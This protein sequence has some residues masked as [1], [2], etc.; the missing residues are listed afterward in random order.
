MIDI[1]ALIPVHNRRDT[2]VRM[3]TSLKSAAVPGDVRLTICV[4]DDG[5][6]DGTAEAI[7][8][9]FPDVR[10]EPADGGLF[11]SGSVRHGIDL[12]LDSQ[13]S[14]LWLLN[15]DMV[16]GTECLG[17]LTAFLRQERPWIIS[18]TIVDDAGKIIYGG[19]KRR[20]LFR[21]RKAGE[22]DYDGNI[23]RAEAVN[24][25]C[26][27]ISRTAL[28]AFELPPPGLYR[29]EGMD[30]YIGLEATRL[31]HMPYVLRNAVCHAAPNETKMWFYTNEQPWRQRIKGLIGPKGLPPKMYWDFCRRFAGPL[32]PL[33][34]PRP[35]L[36]VAF[37][38][39]H[40]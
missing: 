33:V 12:F 8:D 37:P 14:H 6:T 20:S 13:C 28:E 25:N 38:K 7:R 40:K 2:S 24:G 15:D 11:W 29:Q 16:L 27:L 21:F 18:A 26:L 17:H 5:S 4:I 9:V 35:F 1:F 10:V 30:M 39:K 23:C 34:F 31:G 22:S 3:L 32:A 19:I 36:R